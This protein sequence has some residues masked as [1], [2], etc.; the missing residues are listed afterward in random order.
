MA[1]HKQQPD[2]GSDFMAMVAVIGLF[3]A[4]VWFSRDQ[5]WAWI[6]QKVDQNLG[7]ILTIGVTLVSAVILFFVIPWV[8][9]LV[10]YFRRQSMMRKVE[11]VLSR[12][13]TTE[14]FEVTKFFDSVNGM[15][16]TKFPWMGWFMDH[17]H[18]VWEYTTRDG[19]KRIC[20]AAPGLILDRIQKNLQSVYQNIRFR[21]IPMN[22]DEHLPSE[23]IQMRLQRHWFYS[24]Q[25]LKDYQKLFAESLFASLDDVEGRA[26]LQIVMKPL[27]LRKQEAFGEKQNRFEEEKSRGGF[28]ARLFGKNKEDLLATEKKELNASMEGRG[29][30]LYECE[31][32]VYA[33]TKEDLKAVIGTLAESGQENKLI[34][35]NYLNWLLRRV[36]QKLWWRWWVL[37]GMPAI[38]LGPKVK[39]WSV[40]LATLLMLPTMRL[41]VSGL[42]RSSSRRVPVPMGIPGEERTAFMQAENGQY[43]SLPFVDRYA[44]L[45]LLGMQGSGKTTALVHYA[46][47]VLAD[48]EQSSVIVLHDKDDAQKFLDYV[49]KDKKVYIIDLSRPSEYGLNILADDETKADTLSGNLLS[50]FRTAYGDEAIGP[51]SGDF[52]QQ[53]LL[54]LRKIREEHSRW[55]K[56][57]PIIDFRHMR[58]LVSNDEFRE[59][60]AA[61]LPDDTSVQ[62]YWNDQF[63]KLREVQSTYINKIAPILNKYN[64][65][66]ASE[67]VEKILCHP[68]PITLR[69]AIREERAVIVLYTAKYEVGE[70]TAKLFANL[71]MSLIFQAIGSQGEL[72]EEERVK[73]NLF[74]DEVHGY[75]N[76][77]LQAL[78]QESRKYGARTAAATLSLSS[79]REKNLQNVFKQLF[80]NKVVFRTPDMEEANM[81]SQSFAQLYASFIGLRDEDQDRVRVGTDDIMQMQRYHAVCR[82]AVN[83]EVMEPF[84]AQTIKDRENPGYR[85]HHPWPETCEVKPYPIKIP[86]I[87]PHQPMP[88]KEAHGTDQTE[89]EQ[90]NEK[91]KAKE[92]NTTESRER[93]GK[94]TQPKPVVKEIYPAIG[95][96]PGSKI[97]RIVDE[98]GIPYEEAKAYLM[99]IES[100]L[101][102]RTKA[103][104]KLATTLRNALKEKWEAGQT[105]TKDLGTQEEYPEVGGLPP[106]KVQ[107]IV[108]QAG[109]SLQ[110]AFPLL[111]EA[112]EEIRQKKA[113]GERIPSR[114][115]IIRDKLKTLKDTQSA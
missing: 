102:R 10:F 3:M 62:Q 19:K 67:R 91:P 95:S 105:P 108:E 115:K 107:E 98:I 38:G 113:A 111:Q 4:G 27:S 40:H 53:S 76:D 15:L 90:P 22:E 83:G 70:E 110:E 54:A 94:K 66:L 6:L 47:P 104:Y 65:L 57:I 7:V 12:D 73:V 96:L 80:G 37:K 74:L 13:D 8:S 39:L 68:E 17:S 41:R 60:V 103:N 24:I 101:D 11:I 109:L 20:L 72:P 26:G 88:K 14:P 44:N 106:E 75:A 77:S 34:P 43:V 48:P 87:D 64:T 25:T 61:D 31:F 33:E 99:E 100:T 69:K 56:A 2:N 29:K 23:F 30:G 97:K 89:E 81:W 49:P 55:E 78:L 32:R 93:A 92:K 71:L 16:L 59:V 28:W 50:S 112:D 114:P 84:I 86:D 18:L 5:I 46:A 85:K 79:I 45:L 36:L 42:E 21:P 9:K 1:N 63:V 51:Q 58:H 52:L 35:E 82:L